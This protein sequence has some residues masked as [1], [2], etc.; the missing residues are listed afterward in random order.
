MKKNIFI[1][2]FFILVLLVS[3]ASSKEVKTVNETAVVSESSEVPKTRIWVAA[4]PAD[5]VSLAK[6]FNSTLLSDP[7]ISAQL[8]RALALYGFTIDDFLNM[9]LV[10]D[11]KLDTLIGYFIDAGYDFDA[12]SYLLRYVLNIERFKKIVSTAQAN[13]LAISDVIDIIMTSGDAQGVF[14]ILQGDDPKAKE[15]LLDFLQGNTEDSLGMNL[16]DANTFLQQNNLDL[17]EA[18]KMAKEKNM[19]LNELLGSLNKSSV[20]NSITYSDDETISSLDTAADS[21]QSASS[22]SDGKVEESSYSYEI[23]GSENQNQGNVTNITNVYTTINEP[24]KSVSEGSETYDSSRYYEALNSMNAE[25]DKKDA[26]RLLNNLPLIMILVIVLL[27][28]VFGIILFVL[29][30]KAN[31]KEDE[32]DSSDYYE[33]I[34]LSK[35]E[36]TEQIGQD[37]NDKE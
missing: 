37:P 12:L 20:Y 21:K 23:K 36:I 10:L 6:R 22:Y 29:F 9:S 25:P 14:D 7:E 13:D 35:K 28:I 27:V 18:L 24:E 15:I 17:E 26:T 5:E 8:T 19:T 31:T 1:F 32:P 30:L 3:C 11:M 4:L 34:E 2:L 16:E 33:E